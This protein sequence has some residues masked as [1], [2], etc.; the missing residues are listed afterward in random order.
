MASLLKFGIDE[1]LEKLE[2]HLLGQA[3][4]MEF[5]VWAHDDDGTTRVV[6]AL[7]EQV[8][9]EAAGLALDHV[10]ERF[11]RTLGRTGHRL[12]AAALSS[13][14]STASCN[15]RFSLRTMMSGA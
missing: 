9:T 12:A 3:A 7:T 1:G 4:L 2:R 10:S 13:R 15:M 6:D 5:Q 8:L 14:L 11:E